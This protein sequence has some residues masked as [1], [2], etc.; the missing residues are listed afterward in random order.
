MNVLVNSHFFK[1]REYIVK[2]SAG[3]VASLKRNKIQTILVIAVVLL[4]IPA[5]FTEYR[6]PVFDYN[7]S[8]PVYWVDVSSGQHVVVYHKL[9]SNENI[10]VGEV[11]LTW[12]LFLSGEDE[13][14]DYYELEI[15]QSVSGALGDG[16]ITSGESFLELA[17]TNQSI[18]ECSEEHGAGA[19][20]SNLISNSSWGGSI[21]LHFN[22]LPGFG[23]FRPQNASNLITMNAIIRTRP[24]ANVNFS[25]SFTSN[26]ALEHKGW[27]HII[28][29]EKLFIS[30]SKDFL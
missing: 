7:E 29:T 5:L 16:L 15:I 3:I 23:E 24:N 22:V 1:G 2:L 8:N 18:Y 4:L 6:I 26:W 30:A 13:N 27:W 10:T 19:V 17:E 9:I 21:F 14:Y 12:E 11:G 20:E 25:L 28:W